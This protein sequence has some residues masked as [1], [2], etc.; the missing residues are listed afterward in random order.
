VQ[1]NT[2]IIKLEGFIKKYY[3]NQL[4]KGAILGLSLILIALFV[5]SFVEYFGRFSITTRTA[6]FYTYTL[7][8]LGVLVWYIVRPLLGLANVSRKFGIQQASSLIGNHFPEVKDKLLNTLQLQ[9]GAHSQGDR[10]LMASIEQRTNE[11]TPVP[12]V[13]AIAFKKNLKYVK[14]ALLPAASLVFILLVSPGFKKSTERIVNFNEHFE[15]EAPFN[16]F[17]N[18]EDQQAIQ[19]QNITVPLKLEGD[20]IPKDAYIHIGKQRY[21][22][23]QTENG[24][25]S[26]SINNIQ[27][28]E[29]LYFEAGGFSS[30]EYTIDIALKPSLM[31]YSA[32]VDY[33]K[34]LGIPSET[35]RNIG[36]LSVPQGTNIT[37]KFDTKNVNSIDVVPFNK[38]LKPN[39]EK[40]SF[41]HRF[42]KST[43]VKVNTSNAEVNEGD[44][45]F[46]QVNVIPD[47]FPRIAVERKNDS[48]SNKIFYF[49]GDISEK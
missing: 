44:S 10:L 12:F 48:L 15:I 42:M 39:K 22:M 11:L 43:L 13:N 28:T 37:W 40:V 32:V 35:I 18:I 19:N 7:L 47:E 14:Y 6:L 38:K 31:G 21:K 25:F 5:L 9:E 17:S 36:E 33:P 1:K 4:L 34:Y 29:K 20:Q 26:Y 24:K 30:R 41:T 45:V 49:L 46:Y 23:K 27:K 8:S 2:L 3:Q 16:F